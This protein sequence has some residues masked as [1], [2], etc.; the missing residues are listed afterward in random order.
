MVDMPIQ[1]YGYYP[2]NA[3]LLRERVVRLVR[4]TLVRTVDRLELFRGPH[5]NWLQFPK[6]VDLIDAMVVVA[7]TVLQ[8]CSLSLPPRVGTMASYLWFLLGL[9]ITAAS[10]LLLLWGR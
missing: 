9:L 5:V 6:L 10:A 7:T 1:T 2:I 8:S 4:Y 3:L